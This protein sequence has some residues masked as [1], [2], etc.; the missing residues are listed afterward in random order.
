MRNSWAVASAIVAVH[1]LTLMPTPAASAIDTTSQLHDA[2]ERRDLRLADKL[3]MDGVY[4][5]VLDAGSRTVLMKAARRGDAQTVKYLLDRHAQPNMCDPNGV[6]P[7]YLAAEQGHMSVVQLLLQA[8][9]D[10]E[11]ACLTGQSALS[12]AR[13]KGHAAMVHAM[14]GTT[15]VAVVPPSAPPKP[16]PIATPRPSPS[17]A[18][19]LTPIATPKPV[20]VIGATSPAKTVLSRA[21]D[22]ATIRSDSRNIRVNLAWTKAVDLDL[23][24]CCRTPDGQRTLVSF[25]NKGALSASP[26]VM[27]DT[28]AGISI[29]VGNFQENLIIGH[30]GGVTSITFAARIFKDETESMTRPVSFA[31]YDGRITM[32][33]EGGKS[34]EV[35]LT[36]NQSGRWFSIARIEKQPGGTSRIVNLNQVTS[37]PPNGF[38]YTPEEFAR[39]TDED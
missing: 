10:P 39:Y 16:K 18:R 9:A 28:D 11:L 19:P 30:L 25:I 33:L 12:V 29:D 38:R 15:T 17:P 6:T 27:L 2:I 26:Y 7:L 37:E 36:A 32:T 22:V 8:Y 5:D 13:K 35:P 23:Y 21:G 4:I 24:A 31:S 1:L 3:L 34:V 20:A 14:L